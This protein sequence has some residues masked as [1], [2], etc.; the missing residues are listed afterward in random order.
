MKSTLTSAIRVM[1]MLTAA[2][3]IGRVPHAIAQGDVIAYPKA[4][5]SQEQQS[6]DRFECH[7]WSVNQTGFDP[8]RASQQYVEAQS[9]I[10]G[11]Y[12]SPPPSSGRGSVMRGAA[13]GAMV[14]AIAGDAGKGAAAGAL[15]G[16]V[17]R[18]AKAQE[19]AE[20]ERQQVAQQQQQQQQLDGQYQQ[21]LDRY[22]KAFAAC[23]QAR[24][25]QVM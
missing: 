11:S 23:M 3:S 1:F 9:Q 8:N 7:E 17:R 6:R 2:F 4:G 10:Q 12:S 16:G 22:N 13:G 24:D 18:A 5:Q 14:G 20:W 19:R 21:G 25:Y 15:F